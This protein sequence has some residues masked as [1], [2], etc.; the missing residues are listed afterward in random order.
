[1]AELSTQMGS[2]IQ[3]VQNNLNKTLVEVMQDTT[4]V[5]VLFQLR[6]KHIK[7]W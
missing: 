5:R 6:K 3:M 1:M 2:I 7:S 4:M